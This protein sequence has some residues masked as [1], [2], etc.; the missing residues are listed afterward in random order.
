MRIIPTLASLAV[1]LCLPTDAGELRIPAFTAYALP[2]ADS[3]RTSERGGLTRWSDPGQS[4]NWYGR[5][6]EPGEVAA[7]VLVRLPKDSASKLR[8]TVG[9]QSREARIEGAGNEVPVSADFGSFPI[10]KA[11]YQRFMLESLEEKGHRFGDIEALL[12]EGPPLATAHFNLKERRN[13]AS[14]HMNYPLP[15]EPK[16][17]WFYNE[18]TGVTDPVC[19]FYMACGFKRGYFGMQVN[20]PTERR[21]IFSVWD[22]GN[23]AVS[24]SKVSAEDRVQLIAKGEGVVANDFGNEG[25]GGHS[26]LV[27]PWK[28][29]SVQRFL[30]GAKPVDETHTLYA[31][32]WWHPERN[33]WLLIAAMKAPKDGGWLSR[34]HAFS[35]NFWGSTG[36]IQRK[37][38]YGNQWIRTADERWIELTAA[39]F[40]HDPTGR[41]DRLDRFMGVE[42]G[43]FFLSHG[44]FVEGSTAFGERFER[45]ATSQPPSFTL[46][47]WPA[48]P[49]AVR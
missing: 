3:V 41:S 31:G 15:A 10:A 12:L 46:P 36:H 26:H 2:D 9:G 5:F 8:L 38:L 7:K 11:G 21:I 43:R 39:T 44:G 30:L 34:L 33:G 40:S 28:T 14:V 16:I 37:A 49:A 22:S 48:A 17:Q 18:V 4:V 13:A 19:T 1:C 35:E 47:E 6:S 42:Q 25:T 23:E 45:A 32:Y 20:S 29:G 24:R 27:Y